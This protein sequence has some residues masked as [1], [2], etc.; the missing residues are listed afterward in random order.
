MKMNFSHFEQ[1]EPWPWFMADNSIDNSII[2]KWIDNFPINLLVKSERLDGSDKKYLCSMRNIYS[3]FSANQKLGK[4]HSAWQELIEY[5][6]SNEYKLEISNLL[7][8]NLE[9]AFVEVVLNLYEQDCYMSPHTD[10]P[11]KIATHL[12]Y[13]TESEDNAP[14]GEFLV[15]D[16]DGVIAAQVTPRI[17]RSLIFKRTDRSLHSVSPIKHK[18]QRMS[19][20]IVFW[21]EQPPIASPGR[22]VL[23]HATRNSR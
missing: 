1:G 2:S 7:G 3:D 21:H 12:I 23:V 6:T 5:V 8:A 13:L 15:H 22:K 17:G 14:G 10:R 20:Q 16:A 9:N 19:I 11:P 18:H 4:L